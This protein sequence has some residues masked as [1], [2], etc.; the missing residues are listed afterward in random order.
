VQVAPTPPPSLIV[1]WARPA[2]PIPQPTA[3]ADHESREG[4]PLPLPSPSSLG[5]GTR[6]PSDQVLRAPAPVRA[7]IDAVRDYAKGVSLAS[8]P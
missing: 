8:L 5:W 2:T 7:G 6:F 3:P 4:C 1:A